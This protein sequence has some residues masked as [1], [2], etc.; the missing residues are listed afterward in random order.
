MRVELNRTLTI[1]AAK[2]IRANFDGVPIFVIRMLVKPRL[3]ASMVTLC[4][5]VHTLSG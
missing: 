4:G 3:R 2:T 5:V 1:K